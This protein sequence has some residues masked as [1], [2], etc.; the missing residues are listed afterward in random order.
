MK[1]V[2]WTDTFQVIVLYSSM[3]AILVKG[4]FDL[5]GVGVVWERN[6]AMNRTDFFKWVTSN[7]A[8][9][10]CLAEL[11][12]KS[13]IFK[14][15]RQ[16]QFSEV[17]KNRNCK[18]IWRWNYN[19]H[20]EAYFLLAVTLWERQNCLYVPCINVTYCLSLI[21]SLIARTN[22]EFKIRARTL[23]TGG[24]VR[25]DLWCRASF[26]TFVFCEAGSWTRRSA[27][28]RGA[29]WSAPPSSTAPSTAST[30]CRCSDTSP[31]PPSRQHES[32]YAY[33]TNIRQNAENENFSML[34]IN[35]VGWTFV[36]LL[37]VYAGMLIFAQYFDCDPLTTGVKCKNFGFQPTI[38]NFFSLDRRLWKNQTSSFPCTWWTFWAQ[39]PASLAS[40]WLEFSAQAS[41]MLT[42]AIFCSALI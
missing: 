12:W 38:T 16:R 18:I 11:I 1:A 30:N 24:L 3:V 5:G 21:I 40:L 7:F 42:K 35:A 29:R 4:T 20:C 15:F 22:R 19:S 39:C 34:W 37:T 23:I 36:V 10:N 32:T 13:D 2:V 28:R 17:K 26:S 9:N 27:T 8:K 33:H 14:F 31:S 6:A 41:G 25:F